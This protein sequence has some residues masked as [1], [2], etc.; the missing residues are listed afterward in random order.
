MF[1]SDVLK[2]PTERTVRNASVFPKGPFTLFHCIRSLENKIFCQQPLQTGC[3]RWTAGCAELGAAGWEL[4]R[5]GGGAVWA[6]VTGSSFPLCR[7]Q[8]HRRARPVA[9]Q[10]LSFLPPLRVLAEGKCL[11]HLHFSRVSAVAMN[12]RFLILLF[13]DCFIFRILLNFWYPQKNT[14]KV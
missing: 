6:A 2:R 1:L 9:L 8:W 3:C 4:T 13:C 7:W 14:Q 10:P 12:S 11:L 5:G